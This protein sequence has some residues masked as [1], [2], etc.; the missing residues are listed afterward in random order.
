MT[1]RGAQDCPPAC[2]CLQVSRT[3]TATRS[4]SSPTAVALA[5]GRRVLTYQGMN[6]L[7]APFGI[8]WTTLGVQMWGA[9]S[10]PLSRPIASGVVRRAGGRAG[11]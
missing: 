10:E 8:G 1:C 3:V 6:K 5:R 7:D 4:R 9:D 2:C 11:A